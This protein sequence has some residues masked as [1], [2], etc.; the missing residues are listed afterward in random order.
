MHSILWDVKHPSRLLVPDQRLRIA[1]QFSGSRRL[2][3]DDVLD[4]GSHVAGPEDRWLDREGHARLERRLVFLRD[5]R[6]LVDVQADGVAGSVAEPLAILP[7]FDDLTARAIDLAR[8]RART[9]GF[10]PS[11]LGRDHELVDAPKL[12]IR[13]ADEDR[14]AEVRTIA[15]HDRPKVEG[16]RGPP[17]DRLGGQ[18]S[19][20]VSLVEPSGRDDAGVERFDPRAAPPHL[21]V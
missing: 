17:A 18:P 13:L 14:A 5:E 10:D 7:F 9:R 20:G 19:S 4:P 21:E 12:G 8:R 3:H 6:V 16:D 11:S 15:V 1:V 2:A